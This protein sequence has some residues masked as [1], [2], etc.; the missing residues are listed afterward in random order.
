[1]YILSFFIHEKWLLN[2]QVLKLGKFL[3]FLSSP[4]VETNL[5]N[6]NDE[7]LENAAVQ[8]L[9]IK[10]SSRKYIWGFELNILQKYRVKI[11]KYLNPIQ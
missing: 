2:F 7:D 6:D 9:I 8:R 11:S 4:N 5:L 3:A 1:M 10:M